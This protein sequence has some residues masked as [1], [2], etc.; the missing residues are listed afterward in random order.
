MGFICTR[1]K[2]IFLISVASQL[3]SLWNRSLGQLG[4][5]LF[6]I[7]VALKTGSVLRPIGHFRVPKTLTFKMRLGAQH[8]LRKWLLFAW[9]WKMI[10]IGWSVS[11]YPRFETEAL[12]DSEMAYGTMKHGTESGTYFDPVSYAIFDNSKWNWAIASPEHSHGAIRHNFDPVLR[13]TI[14]KSVP[15]RSQR[16]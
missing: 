10:S 14:L 11:T 3:A 15:I 16:P 9:E 8:F 2:K 13:D 7:E 12:G 5:G 6:A 4:N 1:I